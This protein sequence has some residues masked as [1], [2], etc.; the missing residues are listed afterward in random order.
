[1]QV[2]PNADGHRTFEH[3]GCQLAYSV[4]GDGPPVLFIQGTA[5]HGDCWMPQLEAMAPDHQCLW[6]DNRG[7][8]A[9]QPIGDAAI[10]VAQMAE[11]ARV[12][13]DHVGWA[14]AHV[15]GH[16]LGGVIAQELALTSPE[17]VASLSLLCTAADGPGLVAMNA[18]MIW[19][20]LRMSIGT[21]RSRRRAFLEIVLTAAQLAEADLD[22]LAADLEPLYGHDLAVRPPVTMK[23]VKAMRT[24]DVSAR[25]PELAAIPTLVVGARHDLIARRELVQRLADGIGNARH[26]EVEDAAHG[27]PIT[28][29]DQVNAL[30]REHVAAHA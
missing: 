21:R 30:L 16:S 14:R 1:V 5:V 10:S 29:A 20:G 18:A 28:H 25:L 12:L 13:M 26:V 4:A 6:F 24:W 15:V 11:D 22:Q 9:S 17:R 2:R 19:R 27:L 3:R 8:C 23:Q 7:M